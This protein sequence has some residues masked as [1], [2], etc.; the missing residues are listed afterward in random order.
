MADFFARLALTLVLIQTP[1]IVALA[2]DAGSD[3][4]KVTATVTGQVNG[5]ERRWLVSLD[6]S[7]PTATFSTLAPGVHQVWI[8]AYSDDPY[9]RADSLQVEF[10]LRESGESWQ[11]SR[12]ELRLFPF[13][14]LHPRFSQGQGHGNAELLIRS[15]EA[16]AGSARISGDLGGTLFYHQSV[17]TRPIPQRTQSIA[18]SLD[19][20][21]KR[22]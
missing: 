4:D 9:S 5:E 21:L 3:G 12:L 14:A 2:Q 18:L 17:N 22:N 19:L 1:V 6:R 11:V 16:D 20:D 7:L 8:N 15:F 10:T 13:D